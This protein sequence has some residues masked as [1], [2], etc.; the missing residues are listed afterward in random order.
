MGFEFKWTFNSLMTILK[1]EKCTFVLFL[2]YVLLS[3]KSE[4]KMCP[5][6]F[7]SYKFKINSYSNKLSLIFSNE[8]YYIYDDQKTPPPSW[9]EM[10]YFLGK[11]NI[12]FS[13]STNSNIIWRITQIFKKIPVF[14][15][16]PKKLI[17]AYFLPFFALLF[18][19]IGPKSGMKDRLS[20]KI[21]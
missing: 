10:K 7:R 20:K 3:V 5:V 18:L 21:I 19:K 4:R 11:L 9:A 8:W 13:N 17:F 2:C 16:F 1:Q 12:A 6:Y 14:W 15:D